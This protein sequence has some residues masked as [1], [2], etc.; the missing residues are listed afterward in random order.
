MTGL[1]ICVFLIMGSMAVWAD[2]SGAVCG[3]TLVFDQA[4]LFSET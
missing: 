2:Q 3:Q 4:G 1:L